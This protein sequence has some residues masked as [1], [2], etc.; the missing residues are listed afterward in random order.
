MIAGIVC[1]MEAH[2]N[3]GPS[4]VKMQNTKFSRAK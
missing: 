1:Y 2:D 4:Q 3:K